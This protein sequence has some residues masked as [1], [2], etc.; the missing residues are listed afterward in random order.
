MGNMIDYLRWRGDL[1]FAQA[2]FNSVDNLILS[3]LSYVSLDGIAPGEGQEGVTIEEL[4]NAFFAKYSPKDLKKD[5]SF[6][7]RA[8]EVIKEMAKTVRYRDAVV[9]NFVNRVDEEKELQFSALEICLDDDSS[10][11]AYRG[12]DDTI[13]GWKEDFNLSRGVILSEEA[14]VLYLNYVGENSEREL[15]VGG[16]SKGG[17]LAVYAAAM[18]KPE[19]QGRILRVYDNDGP[20]FIGDFLEREEF[21]RVEKRIERLIPESS[22]IGMLLDHAVEPRY[23]ASS[24]TGVRQHDG[25]TWQVLGADFVY[26]KKLNKRAALFNETL[27]DWIHHMEEEKR[28]A[29]IDDF[30][31]VLGVTG[32]STLTELQDGGLR[33]IR[34]MLKQIEQLDPET[35]E[36]VDK[37]IK[38]LIGAWHRFI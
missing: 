27:D 3:Q 30:F 17:N 28:T 24:Q 38:A 20:G 8:P 19:I 34:L 29:L 33:N 6:L 26:K 23:I 14:A 15:R 5:K 21:H 13:V 12:T 1:T 18:C 35:R 25:F 22:I 10:Y 37:L 11:V 32:A 7:R 16:H 9:K 4:S 31:S 2:P 36:S